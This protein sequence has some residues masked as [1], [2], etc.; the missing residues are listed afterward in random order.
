M[1]KIE[2]THITL[3]RG[4]TF[5]S[6]IH[7]YN[8]DGTSY[9]PQTGDSVIFALKRTPYDR[10]PI[11]TKEIDLESLQLS[12]NPSDTDK[13]PFNDYMY[14]IRLVRSGGAVDTFIVKGV[15]TLDLEVH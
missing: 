2:G 9:E 8:S 3:T 4:D 11:M 13:L 14:D 5:L 12:L 6:Q 10:K 15:F 1:Y 7:I